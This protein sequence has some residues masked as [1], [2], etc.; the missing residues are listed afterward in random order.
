M[1]A[2]I[3]IGHRI[4]LLVPK[5]KAAKLAELLSECAHLERA[6]RKE[7]FQIEDGDYRDHWVIRSDADGIRVE[8]VTDG[9]IHL[10]VAVGTE[11]PGRPT[12][13]RRMIETRPQPI[14]PPPLS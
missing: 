6:F 10:P 9:Q 8:Y 14:L 13:A 12:R 11:Q 4:H 5:A 1:K 3:S 7:G 2:V